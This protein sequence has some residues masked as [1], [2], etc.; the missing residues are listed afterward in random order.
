MFIMVA[1]LFHIL[2]RGSLCIFA[3]LILTQ[4]SKVGIVV[5]IL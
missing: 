5:F 2:L 1:T 4:L 3:D